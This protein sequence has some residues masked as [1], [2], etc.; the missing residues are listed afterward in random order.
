MIKINQQAKG[1]NMNNLS[2]NTINKGCEIANDINHKF[3]GFTKE[4][5]KEIAIIAM[6]FLA[7]AEEIK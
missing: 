2:K 3:D 6:A 4:D 7:H 5:I 1:A